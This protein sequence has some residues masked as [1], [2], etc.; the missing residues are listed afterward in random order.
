RQ[1]EPQEVRVHRMVTATLVAEQLRTERE[2][3]PALWEAIRGND[4]TFA[5]IAAPGDA[6]KRDAKTPLP[7]AVSTQIETGLA[8]TS[9]RAEFGTYASTDEAER[10]LDA[11]IARFRPC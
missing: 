1:R 9:W 10:Q 4:V 3:C 2:V 6:M 5:D 11:V 8:S 7:T